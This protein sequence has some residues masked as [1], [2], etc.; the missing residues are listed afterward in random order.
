MG[1][2]SNKRVGE[3]DISVDFNGYP[4]WTRIAARDAMFIFD[5]EQTRDLHYALSRIV[6]F[7]DDAKRLDISRGILP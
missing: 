7:L 2:P 4:R 5:E 3:F 6:E 1:K